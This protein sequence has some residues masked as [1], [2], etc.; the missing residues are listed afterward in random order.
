MSYS[1]AF[2]L[3]QGDPTIFAHDVTSGR[4]R[5]ELGGHVE[6]APMLRQI[7]AL[8]FVASCG[9]CDADASI[10]LWRMKLASAVDEVDDG[11]ALQLSCERVLLGHRMA[12]TDLI[13]LARVR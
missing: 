5:A 2:L 11:V 7:A 3:G 8:E 1:L 6:A 10:R 12:L 4:R 13:F 9:Q